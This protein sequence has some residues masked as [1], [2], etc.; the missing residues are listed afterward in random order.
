MDDFNTNMSDPL[1]VERI[2]SSLLCGR[3]FKIELEVENDAGSTCD[4]INDL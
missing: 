4:Q 1:E 2:S 3:R